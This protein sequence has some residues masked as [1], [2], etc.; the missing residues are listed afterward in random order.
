PKTSYL[1]TPNRAGVVASIVAAALRAE[2]TLLLPEDLL[3]EIRDVTQNK[4]YLATRIA[5]D[6]MEQLVAHLL[7]VSELIAMHHEQIPHICRDVKDDYLLA[8]A[9]VGQA[10]YLVSGDKDLLVLREVEGVRI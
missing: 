7:S 2:F 10:D 1:L 4:P 5:P 3:T 8:Y 6:A 9:V